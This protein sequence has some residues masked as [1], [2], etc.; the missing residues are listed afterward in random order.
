MR[1]LLAGLTGIMIWSGGALILLAIVAR[2]I[3]R[4][5]KHVEEP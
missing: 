3:W 1:P 4:R 2:Y 5:G